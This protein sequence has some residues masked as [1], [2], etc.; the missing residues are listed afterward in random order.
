MK[1]F[2][3]FAVLALYVAASSV[4]AGNLADTVS[5]C[6]E[7]IPMPTEI[8]V[9]GCYENPCDVRNGDVVTF[10]LVFTPRKCKG[11]DFECT[12]YSLHF[13]YYSS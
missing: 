1:S 3:A 10:E 2:G 11:T 4:S 9:D 5:S 13:Y 7:G 8:Y 12:D 6:G